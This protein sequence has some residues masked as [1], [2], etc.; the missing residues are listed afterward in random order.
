VGT[1]E[2][3]PVEARRDQR[4]LEA[5]LQEQAHDLALKLELGLGDRQEAGG[6]KRLDLGFGLGE[7]AGAE[8]L[9]GGP[10]RGTAPDALAL[11]ARGA[12]GRGL[13]AVAGVARVLTGLDRRA[14]DGVA[15]GRLAARQRGGGSGVRDRPAGLGRDRI[16]TVNDAALLLLAQP[17][18][19]G[20]RNPQRLFLVADAPG[21][22]DLVGHAEAVAAVGVELGG[23]IQKLPGLDH[24]VLRAVGRAGGK[25]LE[26]LVEGRAVNVLVARGR[27]REV[28]LETAAENAELAEVV[29]VPLPVHRAVLGVDRVGVGVEGLVDDLQQRAA[30]QAVDVDRAG[31]R[32]DRAGLGVGAGRGGFAGGLGGGRGRSGGRGGVG[33]DFLRVQRGGSGGQGEKKGQ[34]AHGQSFL[35]RST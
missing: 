31:Q 5:A 35:R 15:A 16:A 12:G 25:E 14:A 27:Q 23:A 28:A 33:G 11:I 8:K 24:A 2:D 7:F 6:G 9:S 1:L 17:F 18:E 29:G 10:D 34:T 19:F 3:K 32:F 22:E 26:D 30:L 20:L 4:V 13:F 21:V